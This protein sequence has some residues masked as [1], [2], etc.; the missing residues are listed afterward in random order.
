MSRLAS[1]ITADDATYTL[2]GKLNVTGIY[3]TDIYIPQDPTVGAQ[4]VF[5]FVVETDPDD[6]FEHLHL[7]V[8]MPGGDSRRAG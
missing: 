7:R 4:L 1:V 6:L 5:L 8:E 2:A 3:T